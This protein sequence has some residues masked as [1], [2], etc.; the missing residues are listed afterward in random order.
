MGKGDKKTKRG[1]IFKKSFGK[2]RMK[3]KQINPSSISK[4]TDTNDQI[5]VRTILNKKTGEKLVSIRQKDTFELVDPIKYYGDYY[6]TSHM[7]KSGIS[8]S[9]LYGKVKPS[10]K[11]KKLFIEGKIL[12]NKKLAEIKKIN[13]PKNLIDLLSTTKKSEQVKL[14]K[15]VVLTTD[16]LAALI[17]EACENYGYKLSQYKSEIPQDQF[18]SKKMPLAYEVQD[19]GDVKKIGKTELSDGQLKQ[20]INQRKMTISKFL[21]K[22]DVFHCFFTNQNSLNGV[23]TWLGKKQPHFHY[24][25]NTFGLK[26]EKILKELSSKKY[27]LGNLPHLKITDYGK[28]P[29]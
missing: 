15:G 22:D 25:S 20:A 14:L 24:I 12:W 7:I 6:V 21:E 13:I 26:K 4:K 23:E 1:K 2:L 16:L 19:N 10:E 5:L 27:K 18:D 9:E 8:K 17:F 11:G 3:K 29:E 28:Q